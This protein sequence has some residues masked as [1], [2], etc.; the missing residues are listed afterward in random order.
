MTRRSVD[1]ELPDFKP[2]ESFDVFADIADVPAVDE[3]VHRRDDVPSLPREREQLRLGVV[4]AGLRIFF[5]G[6]RTQALGDDLTKL[7][8]CCRKFFRSIEQAAFWYARLHAV[9]YAFV[10][11]RTRPSLVSR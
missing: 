10:S 5:L 11:N 3:R 4:F 1:D 9:V 7:L 6:R 8:R 2:A